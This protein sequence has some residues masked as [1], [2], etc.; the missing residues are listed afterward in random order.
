MLTCEKFFFNN[1]SSL[2]S[3]IFPEH[4]K[5]NTPFNKKKSFNIISHNN[6]NQVSF[7][8]IL[9]PKFI[10]NTNPSNSIVG[11]KFDNNV[12]GKMTVQI[13]NLQRHLV[14]QKDKVCLGIFLLT[15]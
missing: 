3:F 12:G 10:V 1:I 13:N 15:G 11:I 4:Y 8:N 6:V 9:L 7:E 5:T 2:L 14:I